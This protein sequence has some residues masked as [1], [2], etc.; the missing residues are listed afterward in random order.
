MEL[1]DQFLEYACADPILNNGPAA[2]LQNEHAALRILN[3]YPE[4]AR[5]NIHTAVVCGDVEKLSVF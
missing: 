2:H 3:R 1:V 4:I 5:T